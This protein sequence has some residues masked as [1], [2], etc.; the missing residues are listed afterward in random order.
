MAVARQQRLQ[1][2]MPQERREVRRQRLSHLQGGA[3]AGFEH[4]HRH[5]APGK[6]EGGDR[7]GRAAAHDQ[8]PQR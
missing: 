6:D 7:S 2:Q 8:D 1:A 4:R 5:A 3:G